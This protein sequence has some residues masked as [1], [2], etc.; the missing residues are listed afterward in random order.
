[1][2]EIIK[3]ICKD[4]VLIITRY[5]WEKGE[6]VIETQLCSHIIDQVL[7]D[8]SIFNEVINS[9]VYNAIIACMSRSNTPISERIERI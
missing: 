8:R 3:K 9:K 5:W 4:K 1:M 7:I 2:S 6:S